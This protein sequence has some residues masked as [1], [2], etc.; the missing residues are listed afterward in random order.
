MQE[1]ADLAA[2]STTVNPFRTGQVC[3]CVCLYVV[4]VCVCVCVCVH[5]DSHLSSPW[6]HSCYARKYW[7]FMSQS[8]LSECTGISTNPRGRIATSAATASAH[9]AIIAMSAPPYSVD[10][11]RTLE[12]VL[13]GSPN[14][15]VCAS[16]PPLPCPQ[17]QRPP[18]LPPHLPQHSPEKVGG[19]SALK[20]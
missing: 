15:L 6:T 16:R 12:E 2:A 4:C 14:V 7:A 11:G 13:T 9:V 5:L 8:S 10:D 17:T 1:T 18:D 3:V 19:G 20:R